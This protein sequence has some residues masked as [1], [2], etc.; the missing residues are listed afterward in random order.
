[1]MEMGIV[2]KTSGREA[3]P[4]WVLPYVTGWN[5]SLDMLLERLVSSHYDLTT[6][7]HKN[8]SHILRMK[9]NYWQLK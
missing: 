3:L 2:V 8:L 5:L 7:C 9:L 4:V 6:V 1:M